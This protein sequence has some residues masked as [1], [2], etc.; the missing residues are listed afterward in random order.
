MIKEFNFLGIVV[1]DPITFQKNEDG[2]SALL[3]W[4]TN[5]KRLHKSEESLLRW[6]ILAITGS[7]FQNG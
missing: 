2:F 4:I 5:L 6:N 1:G 7:T 3:N